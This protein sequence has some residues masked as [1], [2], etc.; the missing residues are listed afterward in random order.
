MCFGVCQGLSLGVRQG[1]VFGSSWPEGWGGGGGGFPLALA[2]LYLGGC[3]APCTIVEEPNGKLGPTS[4]GAR[5]GIPKEEEN[6]WPLPIDGVHKGR[7][8]LDVVG[9][10]LQRPRAAACG[11]I[12]LG[13]GSI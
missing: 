12:R 6:E 8:R 3:S 11:G 4:T 2:N 1:L 10:R 7:T 9:P 13:H 5:V